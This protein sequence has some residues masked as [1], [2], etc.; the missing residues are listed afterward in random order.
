MAYCILLLPS[1]SFGDAVSV[2]LSDGEIIGIYNQ[3]N[4]FDIE[5]ALLA[6]V[7]GNADAVKKLAASVAD[8]HRGVRLQAA[9]L[10]EDIDANVALPAARQAA[11]LEY[12]QSIAEMNDYTGEAFDRAYL[13]FEIQFHKNAMQAVENVLLPGTRN[14]ALKQH[15]QS[16][17]P[18]FKHHLN[19]TIAVAKTLGY[20]DE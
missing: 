2:T 3:V 18:H 9:R 20:Y 16:A 14:A 7:K 5:T 10:A 8:D 19:A 6:M 4:G 15:F 17:L 13:L 11:A 12:Y 1:P